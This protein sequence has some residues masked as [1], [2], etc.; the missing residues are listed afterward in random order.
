[1]EDKANRHKVCRREMQGPPNINDMLNNMNSNSNSK[2]VDL[3]MNSNFSESD[4]EQVRS[5][6]GVKRTLNLIYRKVF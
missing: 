1:M 6:G 2:K 4:I 5:N 3:D